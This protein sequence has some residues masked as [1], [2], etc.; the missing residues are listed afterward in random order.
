M[1]KPRTGGTGLLRVFLLAGT[2]IWEGEIPK[3]E[4][5]PHG[6]ERGLLRFLGGNI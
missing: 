1:K 5:A 2:Q 6:G 3:N 4:K